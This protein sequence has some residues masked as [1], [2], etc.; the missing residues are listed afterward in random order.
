[1]VDWFRDILRINMC[2]LLLYEYDRI[3]GWEKVEN[4]VSE[5]DVLDMFVGGILMV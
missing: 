5:E 1:M 4:L 2:I 3:I